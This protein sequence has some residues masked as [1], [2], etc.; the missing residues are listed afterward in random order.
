MSFGLSGAPSTFK[1]AMNKILRL[2][3]SKGDLVNLDA[4][5]VM[6][7]TFEER[8]KLQ[9][10]IFTRLRSSGLTVKLEKRKLLRQEIQ[11]LDVK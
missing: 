9:R 1:I 7:V 11:Y 10:K 4:N 3:L 6:V 8:L 5:L 2:L